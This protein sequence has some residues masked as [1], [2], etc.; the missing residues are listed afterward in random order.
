M[1]KPINDG[2]LK[3]TPLFVELFCKVVS[4]PTCNYLLT[5]EW[6][7]LDGSGEIDTEDVNDCLPGVGKC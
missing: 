3:C 5:E 4:S 6:M 2:I 1:I 7:L